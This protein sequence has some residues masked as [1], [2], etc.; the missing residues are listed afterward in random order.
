MF[1]NP[2]W[3]GPSSGL[4]KWQTYELSDLLGG[5]RFRGAEQL[6]EQHPRQTLRM[7]ALPE[8]SLMAGKPLVTPFG[9]NQ[10]VD[11]AASSSAILLPAAGFPVMSVAIGTERGINSYPGAPLSWE[12]AGTR[13][14]QGGCHWYLPA[15]HSPQSAATRRGLGYL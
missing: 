7:R 10:W 5:V 6:P 11:R 3:P 15:S 4:K 2:V 1:A 9:S 14:S 13:M 12:L 8:S